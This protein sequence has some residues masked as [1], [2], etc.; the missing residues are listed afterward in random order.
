[1]NNSNKLFEYEFPSM[2][3]LLYILHVLSKCQ[4]R[5]YENP[6]FV[7]NSSR[8][9]KKICRF[10]HRAPTPSKFKA[11]RAVIL[12]DGTIYYFGNGNNGTLYARIRMDGDS[13]F[14]HEE[15]EGGLHVQRRQWRR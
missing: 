4:F 11:V 14:D 2:N 1:M 5:I 3:K 10:D 12:P 7:R 8:G 13:I 9:C 15:E 6:I